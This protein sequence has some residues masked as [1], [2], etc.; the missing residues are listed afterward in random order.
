[1]SDTPARHGHVEEKFSLPLF[2]ATV[3]GCLIAILAALRFL[4]PASVWDTQWSAPWWAFLGAF[5]VITLF[6][7]FVEF[8]FHRYILHKPVVPFLSRFYRQHTLHHS[9]TRITRRRTASGRE[10]PYVEN[11]Y[12]ITQPEQHEA[13]F[14]P[15]FTLPVFA[16]VVTPLLALLTWAFPV[17]PWFVAGYVALAA[18]LTLYEVFHAIEHWAFEKWAPL[19]ENRYFGWIW[20]HIYSFHLRHHAVI[21]CNEGISGFFTFPVAD[22]VFRTWINPKTLYVDGGGWEPQDFRSPNPIAPIRWLDRWTDERVKARRAR[23]RA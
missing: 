15:W 8:F 16:L 4:A 22:L 5:L 9:L 21:D 23:A 7:A 11:I 6:N 17:F 13:S 3:A 2:I 20:R 10:L 1:M 19:V 14:F 12:P 18:S